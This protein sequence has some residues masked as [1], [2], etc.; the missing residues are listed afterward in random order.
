[1][2]EHISPGFYCIQVDEIINEVYFCIKCLLSE[3]RLIETLTCSSTL[4]FD[5][6]V[7]VLQLDV[8]KAEL[9]SESETDPSYSHNK[10]EL[11]ARNKKEDPLIISI[12]LI[13]T[14]NVVSYIF[15]CMY[16]Y[17]CVCVRARTDIHEYLFP[18]AC[19]SVC[20]YEISLRPRDSEECNYQTVSYKLNIVRFEVFMVVTIK[21]TV[22]LE[23]TP[24][25]QVVHY[26]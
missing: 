11:I 25:S 6:D 5:E 10:N 21:I 19:L 16:V 26:Q 17:V 7:V 2:V 8:I 12:P 22:F 9:D 13:K 15:V 20:P 24:C 18:M 14:E 3:F 23:V 4:R 1:M